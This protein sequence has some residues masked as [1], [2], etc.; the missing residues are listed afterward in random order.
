MKNGEV[1]IEYQLKRGDVASRE[2]INVEV[3]G[4]EQKRIRKVEFF[5]AKTLRIDV[6]PEKSRVAPGEETNINVRLVKVDDKGVEEPVKGRTLNLK[7]T[8]MED[9]K[10]NPQNQVTTDA[11]GVG[12]L[13]Y[14]AGENDKSVHIEASYKPEGYETTF[15]GS[16]D[17]NAGAYTATIDL[18]LSSPYIP[19]GRMS[20]AKLQ[21]HVDFDEIFIESGSKNPIPY[22][23]G[24]IDASEGRG[25][26]TKFELNDV[27]THGDALTDREHPKWIKKPP[28]SFGAM[29]TMATDVEFLRQ[30]AQFGKTKQKVSPPAKA[31]LVFF[32]QMGMMPITWGAS[33]GSSGLEDFR[34]EFDVPWQDLLDGKPVTIKLPYEEEDPDVKGTWTISFIPGS[35]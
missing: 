8:G 15:H 23:S 6:N 19:D 13:I 1:E 32:T 30:I 24:D 34:L 25:T 35:K 26:F 4:R 14:T 18:D 3:F 7:V 12:K 21:M 33:E 31:R 9:G 28:E 10:I 20:I 22:V 17:L 5:T 11:N 16:A 27:W 29:L 2:S